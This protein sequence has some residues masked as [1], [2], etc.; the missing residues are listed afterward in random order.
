V[1]GGCCFVPCGPSLVLAPGSS[2]PVPGEMCIIVHVG[3]TRCATWSI[4]RIV[5]R[6]ARITWGVELIRTIV[7]IFFLYV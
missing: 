3:G 4:D 5:Q 6:H 7:F 2:C 1:G